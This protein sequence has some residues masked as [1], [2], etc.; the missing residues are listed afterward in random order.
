MEYTD[1]ERT[2]LQYVVSMGMCDAESLGLI[3]SKVMKH[4]EEEEALPEEV[5]TQL[6]QRSLDDSIE[7]I[8]TRIHELGFAIQKA[9]SQDNNQLFYIYVNIVNDSVSKLFTSYT[10]KEID[11]LKKL[12]EKIVSDNDRNHESF[13]VS[14]TD[15]M[16]ICAKFAQ[17]TA[18]QSQLLLNKLVNDGWLNY[19]RRGKYRLSLRSIT[20]LKRDLIEKFGLK[21]ASDNAGYISLCHGCKEIVTEGVRCNNLDCYIR[22][23]R[24]CMN[25]YLT[26]KGYDCAN[27]QCSVNWDQSEPALVGEL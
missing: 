19:S 21:S 10:P 8:N 7:L 18:T 6:A 5:K 20:E 27:E 13:V 12:I 14:S 26:A 16:A 23:H 9:H 1:L 15:A 17:L 2:V 24:H 3:F 25:N 4:F 22:F 11:V